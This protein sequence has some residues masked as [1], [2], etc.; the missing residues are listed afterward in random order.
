[1]SIGFTFSTCSL[2]YSILLTIMYFSKKRLNRVEN[3][4][5]GSLIICNLIGVILAVSCYYTINNMDNMPFLNYIVSKSLL[6]YY[7]AWITIFT[8]YVF[9]IS[10]QKKA[11]NEEEKNKNIKKISKLFTILF[12]LIT[13]LV[14]ILPL[15]FHNTNGIIYS[16]GP[17]A[18][19]LYVVI[20][21][22]IISFFLYMV[23]NL[24]YLRSKEYIPLFVFILIGTVVTIIQ[25]LNPGLLLMTA[26]ETFITM[27]MYFTIEN[28][29]VKMIAEL[30][31]NRSL[32]N[33]TLQEKSNFLFV[34]SNKVT[35]PLKKIIDITN[36]TT[37]TKQELEEKVKEVNNLSRCLSFTVNNI[38]NVST[39]DANNIKVYN[40]SYNPRLLIEKIKLKKEKEVSN[41]IDLRFNISN[42]LPN[43]L[44][45]DKTLLEIVIESLINNAIKNTKEGFIEVTLDVIVKYDMCRIIFVV[46]DSGCGMSIDKVNYLLTIDEELNEEE[47]KRLDTNDV[48]INTIKKIIKKMGGY[49]TLK[50]EDK[51]GSEVKFVLDQKIENPIKLNLN[52]NNEILVA[53]SDIEL[54]NKLAKI[55]ENKDYIV[56]NSIYANDI[57]DKIK[58]GEKYKYILI[59]DSIEERAL[60]ILNKLKNINGFKT[61]V[62]VILNDDT[63]FIKKHFLEDG[64]SDYILKSSMKEDIERIFK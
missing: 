13:I 5:Y 14:C 36:D 10:Y 22:Y 38:M 18:N 11:R 9:V 42:T 41:N 35:N 59:D 64:F 44:Y 46:E 12:F 23:K 15:Y 56:D 17:S 34:A 24:K 54:T 53:S 6:I 27:L 4:I 19:L 31:K 29:D 26:M 63:S 51:K 37:G 1:M 33:R 47:L 39:M 16:Y 48:N 32:I 2:F 57:F 7:L 3:K 49:F 55:L 62:I 50:S 58:S 60:P 20:P 8:I 40:N 21:L 25:K 28:P 43:T 61:P 52:S 45:G 30:N